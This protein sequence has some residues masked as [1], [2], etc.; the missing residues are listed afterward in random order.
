MPEATARECCDQFVQNWIKQ[1]GIPSKVTSDNGPSFQARLWQDINESLGTIVS[2]S[3]IYSPAT[4]GSIERQH[5]DLKNS[6]K[7]VLSTI[8]DAHGD[9]WVDVLPWVVLG[10]HTSFNADLGATP[11]EAVFGQNPRV[12]GDMPFAMKEDEPIQ[13]MLE[14]V[15]ANA[16]RPPMQTSLHK[17]PMFYMPAT[18]ETC[19]HVYTKRAKVTP[20]GPRWDGPYEILE[21]LGKTSLKLKVGEFVN[22]Q[23]RT[24]VR[25]WRSCHPSPFT[26][27]DSASR[28][29]LG[30]PKNEEVEPTGVESSQ[31]FQ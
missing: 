13:D 25:H 15:K 3:P 17:N 14:R 31:G 5:A 10:R 29:T 30:R 16:K 19:T 24:E 18:A 23:P 22:G 4:V 6:L 20:L 1:F 21:R 9:Q 27:E 12:P 8:G 26:P 28:P 7:A 11:A 2:Y